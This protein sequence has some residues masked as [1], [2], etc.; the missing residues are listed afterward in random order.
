MK[1]ILILFFIVFGVH[2]TSFG[3]SGGGC[4]GGGCSHAPALDDIEDSEKRDQVRIFKFIHDAIEGD[5]HQHFDTWLELAKSLKT[6]EQWAAYGEKFKFNQ[7]ALRLTRAYNMEA[8]QEGIQD[9]LKNAM[10]LFPL[11]H[12]IETLTAPA[13]TVLGVQN[14]LP[15]LVV[16]VGGALLSIIAI[17]GLD[18]LCIVLF[19][20]YSFRPVQKAVTAIRKTVSWPVRQSVQIL[21][22]DQL[23]KALADKTLTREGRVTYMIRMIQDSQK[24]GERFFVNFSGQGT[25]RSFTVTDPSSDEK[26]LS[27]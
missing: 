10:L 9:H 8:D 12:T 14:G 6:R 2:L 17:P 18:P 7:I 3:H 19:A 1:K 25:N 11:S 24:N 15:T 27:D 21:K 20:A 22:L 23:A 13:F 16:A 4:K 26:W 5:S